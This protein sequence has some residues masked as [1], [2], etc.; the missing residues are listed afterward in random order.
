M[1]NQNLQKSNLIFDLAHVLFTPIHT[2]FEFN[3]PYFMPIDEGIAIV[4]GHSSHHVRALEVFKD[5]LIL[6]GCGDFL[7]DYEGI[8]GYERFRGDLALMYLVDVD[9]Q[10]GQL[11][12]ARLVPMHM[13]RFRLE[14][15]SASDAKW[16]CNLLNELGKPFATQ[17]RFS[18][19]NSLMLEWR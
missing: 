7:T 9:P 16:L 15:P 14:R 11:V 12:S 18:E 13:R 1:T 5:R 17:T 3:A 10:S 8:S 2:N 6:Y 4:H 19:D